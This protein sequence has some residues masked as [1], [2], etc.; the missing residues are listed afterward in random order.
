[1]SLA[2]RTAGLTEEEKRRMALEMQAQMFGAAAAPVKAPEK[3]PAETVRE[4]KRKPDRKENEFM[5]NLIILRNSLVTNAP[6]CRERAK[7]AGKWVWRD[8]RLM[9]SLVTRIQDRLL[10]TMPA[11]RSDY[12]LAYAR[13]G[14]YELRMDGPVRNGRHVLITDMHLGS[15]CEA[16]MESE[17]VMCMREGSDIGRCGLRAALLEVAPPTE[18][19]DG[20]WRKCEYRDAAGDL[21]HGRGVSI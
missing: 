15:L 7:L 3:A 18:L 6:A 12:Y 14:H 20:K 17:C 1:M 10:A 8:I 11:S 19:Q 4:A 5:M 2:G 13:G 9:L 16:A 21:I